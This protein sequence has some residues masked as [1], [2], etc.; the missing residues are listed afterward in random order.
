[1]KSFL[2]IAITV[3]LMSQ[4]NAASIVAAA[5]QNNGI[6]LPD[7][8][9]ML[10]V[11]NQLRV[12]TFLLGGVGGSP[13]SDAQISAFTGNPAG[14]AAN[15]VEFGRG[16]IG[17]TFG[18]GFDGFF[19]S[20]MVA[21]STA[22]GLANAQIYLWFFKTTGNNAPLSNFSNV[23]H[24]GVFFME[25]SVV[26]NWRIRPET[27]IPN[28]TNVDIADLSNPSGTAVRSGAHLVIGG[29]GGNNTIF[30]K[31]NYTLAAVPEPTLAGL[32]GVGLVVVG[33]RRR[34]A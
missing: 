28:S 3:V 1:M 25:M 17:D 29:F 34:R 24:Q 4:A 20:T 14:L 27:E 7:G 5:E 19:S 31:P 10:P 15:F 6:A 12:G 16:S 13:M 30:N 11:G 26:P 23:T 21:N 8:L 22:L 9:T 33:L 18:P 32:V 2:A